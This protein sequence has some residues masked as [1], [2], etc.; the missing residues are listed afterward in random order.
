ML[1]FF[2]GVG[3]WRIRRQSC[4]HGLDVEAPTQTTAFSPA[5]TC[6]WADAIKRRLEQRSQKKL[7]PDLTVAL[8]EDAA[9]LEHERSERGCKN[10][11]QRQGDERLDECK[12][13]SPLIVFNALRR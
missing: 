3:A 8:D 11:H 2:L 12:A 9:A 10:E 13:A 7:G 1:V 5:C 6:F 4:A